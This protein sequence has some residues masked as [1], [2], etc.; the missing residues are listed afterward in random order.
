MSKKKNLVPVVEETYEDEPIEESEGLISLE[1]NMAK[2]KNSISVVK[3]TYDDE[4]IEQE[5][6]S[7]MNMLGNVVLFG[8]GVLF[9]IVLF[10]AIR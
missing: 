4:P 3:E 5:V 9:L 8:V 7:R 2:K 6:T 1:N 10:V